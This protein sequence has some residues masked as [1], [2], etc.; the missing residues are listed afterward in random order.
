M[1]DLQIRVDSLQTE[2]QELKT[3]LREHNQALADKHTLA[4]SN[5]ELRLRLKQVGEDYHQ[6]VLDKEKMQKQIQELKLEKVC[7]WWLRGI[8]NVYVVRC[9]RRG[10]QGSPADQAA[11]PRIAT[12][13]GRNCSGCTQIHVPR[14]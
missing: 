3:F 8:E 9:R 10:I 13:G 1:L 4:D 12:G 11:I 6:A 2:C 7:P 5:K 14:L